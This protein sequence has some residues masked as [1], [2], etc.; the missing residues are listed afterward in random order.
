MVKLR[1]AHSS[2][3]RLQPLREGAVQAKGIEF[4]WETI[5]PQELFHHQ[6]T[7]N[8]F[9]VFEFSISSYMMTRDRPHG[10][11][12]WDWVGVPVFLSRAFLAL[13]TFVNV[14]SGME[15]FADLKGKRFGIP[16]FQMTAGLWMRA[17]IEDLYGVRAQDVTWY[18]GRP[19]EASHGVALGLDQAPPSDV[20]IVW[21]QGEPRLG[22]LLI[23]GEIDAAYPD[24]HLVISESPTVRRL[25]SD[26]G[27]QFVADFV[28]KD[29][30]TPV[31]HTLLVQ[32]RVVEEHPWVPEALFEA[33]EASKQ[34]AYR[35]DRAT[36]L[37]FKGDDAEVQAGIF[38]ADP[39][40]SG[41][42]AN[43]AML[44]RGAKQ[45]L[46]EGLIHNPIDVDSLWAESLRNS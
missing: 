37:L 11:A 31:N 12:T 24:Q 20:P 5:P 8:D 32:R 45:S 39:Y 34:E 42:A 33:F 41:L 27:R 6:L 7:Q 35:R 18:V 17:M 46:A 40:P 15:T 23:K 19:P 25:F 36:G 26:G 1:A 13:N 28:R 16:D 9:D 22:D 14:D 3:P 10:P 2:N 44:E 29:G 30:F 4:E 38:G 21:P 43:R